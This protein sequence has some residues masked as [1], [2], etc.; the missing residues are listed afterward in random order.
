MMVYF[1]APQPLPCP[2]KSAL[3]AA[4]EMLIALRHLNAEFVRAGGAPL[5]IGIGI[6]VGDAVVGHV[7]TDRLHQYTAI[8]DVIGTAI[9][10]EALSKTLDFPVILSGTVADGVGGA[11]GLVDLGA[12]PLDGTTAI[13]VFG[14]N[15]PTGPA[16]GTGG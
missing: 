15:P 12:R 3:E 10:L 2:E 13:R 8:G 4:H 14:W 16:T 9:R 11:G 7:G 5:R 6:H 1:G